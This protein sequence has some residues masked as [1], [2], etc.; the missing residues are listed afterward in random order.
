MSFDFSPEQVGLINK[1]RKN[2]EYI[3]S[4]TPSGDNVSWDDPEE[5]QG[6][7]AELAHDILDILKLFDTK[8]SQTSQSF[9]VEIK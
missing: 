7:A 3:A 9:F 1:V 2:A 5:W 6:E 8:P 4:R